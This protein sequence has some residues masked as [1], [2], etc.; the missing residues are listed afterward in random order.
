MYWTWCSFKIYKLKE[1]QKHENV[2][3]IKKCPALILKTIISFEKPHVMK[4]VPKSRHNFEFSAECKDFLSI[5]QNFI[6]RQIIDFYSIENFW[7]GLERNL[8]AITV[9]QVLRCFVDIAIHRLSFCTP[10][11][12]FHSSTSG[13]ELGILCE[14]L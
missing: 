9:F 6:N 5:D 13:Y 3:W 12:N 4:S 2:K 11:Q 1:C 8:V 14:D 7:M 10:C